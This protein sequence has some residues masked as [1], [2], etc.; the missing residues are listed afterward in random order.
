DHNLVYGASGVISSTTGCTM[1]TNTVGSDP[2]FVNASTAPYDFHAQSGG[3]GIDAGTTVSSVTVDF[4]KVSRP[5][6]PALDIGAYEYVTSGGSSGS[7]TPAVPV[8]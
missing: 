3:A 4:D 6:G 8:I 2:N 7:S 5:Q 1:G